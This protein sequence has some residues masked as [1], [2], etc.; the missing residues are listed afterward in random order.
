VAEQEQAGPA[1]LDPL[2]LQLPPQVLHELGVDLSRWVG[3]DMPGGC[4]MCSGWTRVIESNTAGEW[5]TIRFHRGD[6][7]TFVYR[8]LRPGSILN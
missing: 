2:L 4:A 7:S 8:G 3:R 1:D 5:A 6:C